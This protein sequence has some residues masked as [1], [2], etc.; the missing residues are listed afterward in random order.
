[1]DINYRGQ[2]SLRGI[3]KLD[4]S[5]MAAKIGNGGGHPNA[6]GGKIESYKD[7]FVYENIRNFVQNHLNE[8]TQK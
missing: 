5:K 2:F 1:M 6:S 4:L 7:S 3:N 8:S